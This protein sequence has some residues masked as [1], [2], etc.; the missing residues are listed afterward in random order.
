VG[1]RFDDDLRSI[2]TG[3]TR[4]AANDRQRFFH[5][6]SATKFWWQS[7]DGDHIFEVEELA[8]W[9][10]RRSGDERF[11]CRYAHA[12]VSEGSG[13]VRHF[14]GAV[15]AYDDAMLR[16]WD[17]G[18]ARAGRHAGYTKLWRLDG[19]VRVPEWK[20]TLSDYF[21]GNPLVGEYLGAAPERTSPELDEGPSA[22]GV[23]VR[24][25][26]WMPAGAGVRVAL[27]YHPLPPEPARPPSVVAL[28]SVS[29]DEDRMPIIE[30]VGIEVRK[31]VE[32]FGGRLDLDPNIRLVK[33]PDAYAN[34]PLVR[35]A[36]PA[37]REEAALT[38][39]AVG[40]LAATWTAHGVDM[41]MSCAVEFEAG[42]RMVRV[43]A[44]GHTADLAA[45]LD[46]P[47]ALPPADPALIPGWA[48]GVAASLRSTVGAGEDPGDTMM[49]TGVFRFTRASLDPAVAQ[50]DVHADDAGLRIEAHFADERGDVVR[51][52]AAAALRPVPVCA[53]EDA[54]CRGCGGTYLVCPCSKLLDG[55]AVVELTRLT[56]LGVVWT[57]RP[58]A[59]AVATARGV[60]RPS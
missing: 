36:G 29:V 30:W 27:S 20:A 60:R 11:L 49:P 31:A 16:R 13:R 9:P 51:A 48:D 26:G 37:A 21:R 17:A 14:D 8:E 25:P 18:I 53:V 54:R 45:W 1:P 33:Y 3:V 32:R 15:R 28:D 22:G 52:L 4:H 40:V 6:V 59:S 47:L 38:V 39:R 23:S 57:D 41:N 43:A 19:D 50:V 12:M 2:P 44:A 10:V 24:A 58:D 35:H 5:G 7:R 46:G 56:P 42:D 55:G 34:L